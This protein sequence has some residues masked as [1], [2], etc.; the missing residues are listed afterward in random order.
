M[1]FFS[2]TAISVLIPLSTCLDAT[3]EDKSTNLHRIPLHRRPEAELVN[4]MYH[5]VNYSTEK[6]GTKSER[7]LRGSV[8]LDD[9]Y[10]NKLL[11]KGSKETIVVKD[12]LDTQYYAKVQIGT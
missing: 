12:F 1:R 5:H 9:K 2:L 10:A 11:N 3:E 8:S 7:K 6:P 4:L